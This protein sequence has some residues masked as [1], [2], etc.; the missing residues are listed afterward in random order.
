MNQIGRYQVEREIGRGAM[1]VVYLGFDPL[2]RR[3]VAVKTVLPSAASPDQPWDMLLKRL[4]REAQ[5]A[6]S[7]NHPNI[8]GVYDVVPAEDRFSVVMEFIDGK[9]LAEA[10]EA[11]VR[12]ATPVAIRLLKECAGALDHAHSR[13]IVHR[14]IKPAN[15]MVD[16]FG[17]AKITDFGIAKLM[18][19]STNITRGLAIGTLEYMSPEQLKADPIDGRSDQFSLG[20]VAYRLLTSSPIFDVDSL[21]EWCTL[22][23]T[24]KPVAAT[25]RNPSLPRAVDAVLNRAMAV[26]PKQRFESCAEFAEELERALAIAA[27]R[28]PAAAT[29]FEANIVP[30]PVAEDVAPPVAPQPAE[31]P[32]AKAEPQPP[33]APPPHAAAGRDAAPRWWI[34]GGAGLI[35]AITFLAWMV[36][37]GRSPA[38]IPPTTAAP[39]PSIAAAPPPIVAPKEVAKTEA[40]VVKEAP[41]PPA[42]SETTFQLTTTPPA[43]GAVFDDDPATQCTTPCATNLR[44]G[45]HTFVVKAA[46]YRDAQRLI[47][48]PH[49]T[50]L[51]VTLEKLAGTLSVTSTPPGLAVLIDGQDQGHKTPA[52]IVLPPGTHRVAVVRGAEKQEFN[53]EVHDGGTVA[54]SVDW[55]Q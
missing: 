14:D 48:V 37:H 50:A 38:E 19:S 1:G 55:S 26:D 31:E 54:R 21:G 9:S 42:P 28:P 33:V 4:T 35:V 6:A 36:L 18:K 11:G 53:V 27:V 2:L 45:R 23:L 10:V 17:L 8:M 25:I 12:G 47:E 40:R 7:L 16:S 46:G 52:S 22:L 20:A 3:K 15:I 41:R 5:A 32:V 39:T 30:P 24:E 43:A 49:D 34:V 44:A 51:A 13:G 29:S